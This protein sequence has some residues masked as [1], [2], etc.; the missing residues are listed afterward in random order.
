MS[1]SS[2]LDVSRQMSLRFR[3]IFFALTDAAGLESRILFGF[4]AA[5]S[6]RLRLHLFTREAM[7]NRPIPS[8]TNFWY[9]NWRE[10][11]EER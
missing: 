9:K 10:S 6:I 2:L 8:A 1:F 11:A 7:T 3:A 5:T 4:L